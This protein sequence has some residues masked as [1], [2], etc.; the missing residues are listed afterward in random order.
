[1][2][3][4]QCMFQVFQMF[5]IY[6]AIVWTWCCK[7]RL[8]DVAHVAYVANVSEAYCK[9][10]FKMFHLFSDVC[11]NRF[12]Y[13]V[14]YVSHICCNSMFLMFE[15]FQFYVATAFILQ[16]AS[17]LFECFDYVLYTYIAS[18]CSK[19]FICF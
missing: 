16:V 14:A 6:F 17:V 9:C 11:C 5:Q 19:C 18:A 8:R 3:Q 15:L 7:S 4:L 2:L 13:D 1:M 12:W 10:L